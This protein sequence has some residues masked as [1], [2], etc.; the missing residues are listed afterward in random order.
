MHYTGI[1]A[2]ELRRAFLEI[3]KALRKFQAEMERVAAELAAKY[4]WLS[5]EEDEPRSLYP[6]R[7]RQPGTPRQTPPA[8]ASR[9]RRHI[10]RPQLYPPVRRRPGFANRL[11]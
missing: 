5:D 1:D 2:R 10:P 9:Y 3:A 11:D 6:D 4:P 7:H 8:R